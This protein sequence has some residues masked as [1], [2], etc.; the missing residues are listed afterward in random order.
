MKRVKKGFTLA[1]VLITLAII[2][3]VAALT[4]PTLMADSRYQLLSSRIAKFRSTTEDAALAHS[5][6]NDT[7]RLADL[8]SIVLYKNK[9]DDKAFD[10][11]KNEITDATDTTLYEL[12]DDTILE[13]SEVE[14]GDKVSDTYRNTDDKTEFT[15]KYGAESIKLVFYPRVSGL[16]TVH[17]KY[18]FIMTDKGYV[19][20]S[21]S[22]KC[23]NDL[24]GTT[25][26]GK[27][28]KTLANANC[29]KTLVQ[30]Y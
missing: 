6:M 9:Q 21:S 4:I 19:M 26:N 11:A 7:I 28:N 2:G 30:N 12:K 24:L 29:K 16:G 15:Q 27:M 10:T 17:G 8:D 20:P 23:L 22:D 1:E 18:T 13:V 3:V 25:Y 5:A 14:D